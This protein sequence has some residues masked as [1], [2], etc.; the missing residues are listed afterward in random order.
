MKFF[1]NK[2]YK[3]AAEEFKNLTVH[4]KDSHLAPEAQYYTG[5]AHEEAEKYYPAF[6]AYQKTID[7][8]P[9]A[10]RVDEIINRQYNL[11]NILYKKHS[12]KLMGKEIAF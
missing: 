12:G 6:Q 3:R 2:N 4:F 7:V 11:G 9:F 10:K 5:R 8:Y 1:K